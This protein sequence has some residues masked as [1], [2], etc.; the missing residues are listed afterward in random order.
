MTALSITNDPR[1]LSTPYAE[2][3][4]ITPHLAERWLGKNTRNRNLRMRKVNTYASDIA[5]GDWLITGDG[6]KFDH[7]GRLINGQ[8][9]LMAVIESG[10]PVVTFVFW[11]LHPDAQLV[12]DTGAK[13][14]AADALKFSGLDSANVNVMSACARIGVLWDEGAYRYSGQSSF[15]REVT[16]T[17]IIDWVRANPDSNNAASAADALR[18]TLPM[19]PSVLAFTY[20][21]TS[22]L[23]TD[24]AAAF[25]SD[26]AN[27]RTRGKGDPIYTL[28]RRYRTAEERKEKFATAQHI[29]LLFRTWNAYRAGESLYALKMGL[30]GS[31][32]SPIKIAPPT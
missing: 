1:S 11:G 32:G 19:P 20:L 7:T 15:A 18:K 14:S 9:F 13:R 6:P 21:L 26:A 5:S 29:F 8:H 17:E 28:L 12:M 22:R 23:D 10:V 4:E 24:D 16:N 30:A 25:F 31:A 2:L 3:T 27:M